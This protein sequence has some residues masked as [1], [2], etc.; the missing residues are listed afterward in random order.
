M[1]GVSGHGQ[2]NKPHKS[3]RHAGRSAREKHAKSKGGSMIDLSFLTRGDE[4]K[5]GA[6]SEG[7]SYREDCE[8]HQF[9]SFGRRRLPGVNTPS[10]LNNTSSSSPLHFT[11]QRTEA[12]PT[13]A[14]IKTAPG[15]QGKQQRLQASKALR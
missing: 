9:F 4:A 14:S 11:N 6:A 3:G 12:G 8:W 13:R 2:K 1:G 15:R 7:E 10:F 5:Q